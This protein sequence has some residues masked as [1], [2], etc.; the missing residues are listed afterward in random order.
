MKNPNTTQLLRPL[1]MICNIIP[2]NKKGDEY[3]II[4]S[5][6]EN[7]SRSKYF[8]YLCVRNIKRAPPIFLILLASFS[9]YLGLHTIV[10]CRFTCVLRE[11]WKEVTFHYF[12]DIPIHQYVPFGPCN[13]VRGSSI[14]FFRMITTVIYSLREI[15]QSHELERGNFSNR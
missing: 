2:G 9:V 14:W 13:Q 5:Q 15:N 8:A 1:V 4:P 3:N 10:I 12:L 6:S 11:L 7:I